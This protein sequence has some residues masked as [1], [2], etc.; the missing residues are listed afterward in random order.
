[1]AQRSS[2]MYNLSWLAASFVLAFLVWILATVQ[3]DPIAQQTLSNVPV[4]IVMRDGYTV[5]DMPRTPTVRVIVQGQ[6]SAIRLLTVD[7]ISVRANLTDVEPGQITVPL[8]VTI[9]RRGIYAAD[10]QPSQITV[11]VDQITTAQKPL[12]INVT[13]APPVDFAYDPPQADM[14]QAAVTGASSKVNQVVA[15]RAQLDL[16]NR[17]NPLDIVTP[18]VPI[19]V[20]GNRVNDVTVE[21]RTTTVSVNIYAREDVRQLTIRPAIKLDTLEAGYMLTSIGYEPQTLYVSGSADHLSQLPATVETAPID[22]SG[23]TEDFSVDVE[24]ELP[25]DVVILSGSSTVTVT[26]G[27]SAQTTARQI[28]TVPIEVIGLS[29]GFTAALTPDII[30]V[31]I[32]GPVSVVNQ[33]SPLDVRAIVDLNGLPVGTQEVVPRVIIQQ[34]R[35]SLDTTLLPAVVTVTIL[36]T[37]GATI[38]PTSTP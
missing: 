13:A 14:L 9:G 19:D 24:V 7:D 21:P 15:V 28:D 4:T 8:T 29:E 38:E 11:T 6:Q 17:R 23:R 10:T 12:E 26:L 31:V 35:A 33:I 34:G 20:Q 16:S 37:N 1:M 18:L 36:Q 5:I 27:I 25:D 30:S 2:L 3:A 22:L 32:S